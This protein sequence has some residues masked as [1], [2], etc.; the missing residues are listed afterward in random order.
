MPPKKTKKKPS[1]KMTETFTLKQAIDQINSL[2]NA[3]NS[4]RNWTDALATLVHYVEEP[5]NPHITD[6]TKAEMADKYAD[7]NIVPIISDFD[8]VTDIVQNKI[9]SSRSGEIIAIDTK[10][11]Y[12]LA[13]VRLTQKDSPFQLDK[14]L[15][16][17][18][19]EKVKEFDGLSNKARNTNEPKMGLAENPDFTWETAQREYDEYITTKAFTATDKGKKDLRIAVLA[20]LYLLQRPRRVQDFALLQYY[21]K[22]PTEREATNRNIVYKDDD[23]LMFS[24]DVF[25]TRYRVS[26]QA[27]EKKELL[28]RYVKEVNPRLASLITDY[29]KK[30]N[31][32]D[33]SKLTTAEKRANKQFFVFHLEDN[34]DMG[35]SENTF[36]K[37]VS[38]AFKTVFKKRKG[39]TVNSMRHLFNTWIAQNISEFNDNK[40]QEIAIDVGDT[41]RNLPT[42]LRYRIAN[43]DVAQLEKTEIEGLIHDNEYAK[44]VMMADKEDAAS[45]GDVPNSDKL[46]QDVNEVVSPIRDTD[47]SLESLYAQLGRA[48]Y[49]MERIKMMINKKLSVN[50]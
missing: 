42:N 24:L 28:P 16:K 8:N 2:A 40:L 39:L 31:I 5:T 35:Y 22:P 33:M 32:R 49:E 47:E 27:T 12:F 17:K 37:V 50:M 14:E 23:K 6:M 7:V 21:S 15:S 34:P 44:N 43:Q 36:S 45:V 19:N 46:N 10:K 13:V 26:G 4:R 18:Y 30:N 3:P 38:N 20:G 1:K 9:R 29:I 41:P 25:K 11:Q 48:V